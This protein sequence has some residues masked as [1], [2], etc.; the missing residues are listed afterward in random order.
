[1]VL[2]QIIDAKLGKSEYQSFD[3]SISDILVVGLNYDT[4]LV[5]MADSK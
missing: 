4:R 1:M 2:P 3:E 5:N